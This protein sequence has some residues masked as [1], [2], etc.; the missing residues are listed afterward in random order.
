MLRPADRDDPRG[1]WIE[2][3]DGRSEYMTYTVLEPGQTTPQEIAATGAAIGRSVL[4]KAI[5]DG[6]APP[7]RLGS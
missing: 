1:V 4:E 5:A 6:L 7:D 2:G 3:D